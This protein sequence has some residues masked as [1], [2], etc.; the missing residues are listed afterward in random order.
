VQ[1]KK[2]LTMST[3]YS[4]KEL[5]IIGCAKNLEIS[6]SAL[7][8]WQNKAEANQGTIDTRGRGNYSSDEAKTIAL[9]KK[10]LRDTKDALNILKKAISILGN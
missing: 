6:K 7:T 3:Q 4:H 8:A 9:L 5:G 2:E 10:E 1:E